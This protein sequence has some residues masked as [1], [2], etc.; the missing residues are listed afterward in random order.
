MCN[1]Y[2]AYILM[3]TNLS[4]LPLC[5]IHNILSFM[6]VH[7]TYHTN[8]LIF[9]EK[10]DKQETI[11]LEDF[12]RVRSSNRIYCQ[13]ESDI[14]DAAYS[15]HDK[16]N[17]MIINRNIGWPDIQILTEDIYWI[18]SPMFM[19]ASFHICDDKYM[20]IV[21]RFVCWYLTISLVTFQ[22]TKSEIKKI[23]DIDC[24]IDI[25]RIFKD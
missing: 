8:R 24:D 18:D 15:R 11:Y 9:Y 23:S 22:V 4:S 16:I 6:N 12:L 5:I 1:I 7:K 25:S 20:C 21:H 14:E 19:V 13:Y 10:I 17:N 3:T 2:H